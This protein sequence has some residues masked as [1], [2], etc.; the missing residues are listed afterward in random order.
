MTRLAASLAIV[1]AGTLLG[2]P[3]HA[4]AADADGASEGIVAV[5]NSDAITGYELASRERLMIASS[6]LP[7]TPDVRQK[8]RAE[9]LHTLIDER[10]MMQEG[11]KDGVKVDKDDIAKGFATVAQ[12]NNLTAD[13]F[14]QMMAQGGVPT[15]T[16][17]DE[18]E[19]QIA[20]GK[21]IQQEVRPDITVSDSEVDD[22][23]S[24]LRAQA[25]KPQFLIAEIFLPVATG[26]DEP[27]ARQ[28]ADRLEFEIRKNHAPFHKVAAQFS[29]AP[30]AA[31]NGGDF[32]W[33][34]QGQLD[35]E[36]DALLAVMKE[37]QM[38]PPVR[39]HDGL[40]IILMRKKSVITDQ[41]LPDREELR[42]KLGVAKLER[43][44]RH[45][46]QQLKSSAFIER[47]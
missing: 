18:I 3:V 20:W 32:G 45:L 9:T 5:V 4:R 31:T 15:K 21:V 38:S 26:A 13:Q 35:P 42:E 2:V 16:L 24:Q 33:V 44:Q 7:D 6:G 22:A 23:L 12:Q 46:M 43:G 11:A 1:L 8:A 17:E 19:A 25:G 14:R 10:L 30:G 39:T 28:L 29:Q 40:Y 27:A 36:L 37:G 34:Q 47:R 41:T